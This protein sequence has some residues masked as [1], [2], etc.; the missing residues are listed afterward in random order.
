MRNLTFFHIHTQFNMLYVSIFHI[1]TL[2]YA[3][4]IMHAKYMELF[5]SKYKFLLHSYC[6]LPFSSIILFI[7]DVVD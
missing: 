2:I 7:Q 4:H 5:D 6:D 3:M 1:D